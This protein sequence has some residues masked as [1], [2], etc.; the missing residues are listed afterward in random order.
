MHRTSL[1]KFAMLQLRNEAQAE[2]VVQETLLAAVQ[3][4]GQFSGKSSVRTW[5]TG[6]LK[7]KIIDLIHKSSRERP[8]ES[9]S[10]EVMGD[11]LDALFDEDGR[12]VEAQSDWGNP[13]ATLSQS[14]FFA[15][16]ERCME[17]LPKNTARVFAMREIMGME[18]DEI[19][20]ELGITATNCGVLLYRART[21]LRLCLDKSWFAGAR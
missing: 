11:D 12:H 4:A 21:A 18:N 5:L 14:R 13:E 20:N 8:S 15:A 17:G 16:L 10:D 3:G 7:Y 9:K 6:I 1:F 2:D 19:C